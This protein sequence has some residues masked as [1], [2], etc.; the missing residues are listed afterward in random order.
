MEKMSFVKIFSILAVMTFLGFSPVKAGSLN[1]DDI[2]QTII[3]KITYPEF[4]KEKTLEGQVMVTFGFDEKGKVIIYSSVSKRSELAEYVKEK[5]SGILVK[6][7]EL[8]VEQL[9]RIE[10][11]FKL[12]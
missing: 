3:K 4:A 1:T 7:A 5:I 8:N 12:L 10:I 11:T 6:G 9:Y 2:R